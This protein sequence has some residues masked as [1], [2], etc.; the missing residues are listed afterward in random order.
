MGEVDRLLGVMDAQLSANR[1]LAG[2][3]YT[4]ADIITWPWAMLAKRLIDED[5]WTRAFRM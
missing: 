4:I 1:Y 3:D 5:V 2:E